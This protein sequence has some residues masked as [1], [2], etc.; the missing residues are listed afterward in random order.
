VAGVGNEIDAHLLGGD[1]VG[2]VEHPDEGG[3]VVQCSNRKAPGPSR[4][5]DSSRLEIARTAA[6][7]IFERLWMADRKA[8]I[9]ALDPAT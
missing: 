7:Y 2:S 1:D 3:F 4:L 6:E 5:R 9:A 8:H